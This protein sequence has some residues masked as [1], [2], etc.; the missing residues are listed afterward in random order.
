MLR[1][2]RTHL[3]HLVHDCFGTD[4]LEQAFHCGVGRGQPGSVLPVLDF[5]G[6]H[7]F[8]FRVVPSTVGFSS[9]F[10]HAPLVQKGQ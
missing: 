6:I 1:L 2:A 5:S 10:F 3:I 4:L 8:F 7:F 9:R